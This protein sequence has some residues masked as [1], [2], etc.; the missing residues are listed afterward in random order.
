LRA[1][2]ILKLPFRGRAAHLAGDAR[3]ELG[4]GD[5]DLLFRVAA[6]AG[7]ET[8]AVVTLAELL[9]PEDALAGAAN[10][11][12]EANRAVPNRMY[13]MRTCIVKFPLSAA[14]LLLA[15]AVH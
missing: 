15:R 8:A 11:A 9:S 2:L 7:L 1:R 6:A 12:A 3:A 5:A 13:G 10:R 14:T 4:F